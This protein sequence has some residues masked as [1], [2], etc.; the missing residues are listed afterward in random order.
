MCSV[1]GTLML[2]PGSP[3]EIASPCT[4][5]IGNQSGRSGVAALV[6]GPSRFPLLRP[7]N[8]FDSTARGR[9]VPA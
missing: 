3:R 7:R 4:H 6:R 5:R 2:K 9:A 1:V 8:A